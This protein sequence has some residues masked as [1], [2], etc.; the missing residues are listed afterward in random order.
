V[1]FG[2]SV[3]SITNTSAL[4]S[5]NSLVTADTFRIRYSI[6]GS[7]NYFYVNSPGT[8]GNSSSISNLLPNTTYH[9]RIS[10]IC[11]G[12]SSGYGPVVVFTTAAGSV[13]CTVPYGLSS[14]NITLNSANIS[15]TPLV[16]AD[17]FLIRYSVS[18]TTNYIWKKISGA[19]GVSSSQLTGLSNVTT[20]QWQVRSICIGVPAGPYSVSDVFTTP[21]VKLANKNLTSENSIQVYP[22]PANEKI[23]IDCTTDLNSRGEIRLFDLSGRLIH[24]KEITWFK[25]ENNFALPLETIQ[26]GCYFISVDA[27]NIRKLTRV[28]VE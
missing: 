3:S 21:L 22:N 2:E 17:S 27:G 11:S 16:T 12:S 10:S 8:A 13:A 7:T 5:W 25:G 23:F 4:V 20:Y 24:F 6:N 19:G 9:L 26:P 28:V 18:G 15:W 14:T 1:P